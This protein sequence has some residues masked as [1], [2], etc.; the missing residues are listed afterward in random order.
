MRKPLTLIVLSIFACSG[1]TCRITFPDWPPGPNYV[2]LNEADLVLDIVRDVGDIEAELFGTI[3]DSSG[4]LVELQDQ[5]AVRVNDAELTLG[6]DDR[7]AAV[8]AAAGAYTLTVY[9]PTRGVE[10]TVIDAPA[11]FSITSPASGGGASLSGFTLRWTGANDRYQV[12]LRISQTLFGVTE[13][14]SFGPYTDTG[15]RAFTVGDLDRFRQ[16]APLTLTVTKFRTERS[17][18]GF[19]TGV[20]TVKVTARG[21]ADPRR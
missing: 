1:M 3:K 15:S 17:V 19:R 2:P 14:A 6:N 7:Y 4:R 20:V 21:T 10:T 8:L 12:R 16:G 5:Q 13:S 9:E 18:A 11:D